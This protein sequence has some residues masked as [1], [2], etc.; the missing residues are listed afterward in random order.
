[1]DGIFHVCRAF[2]DSDVVHVEDRVDPVE[3]MAWVGMGV[4]SW[5]VAAAIAGIHQAMPPI[6]L[7]ICYILHSVYAK[8]L[9][10]LPGTRL[11]RR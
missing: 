4:V 1:M 2:D 7:F 5:G 3:G 6:I 8:P 10:I 9:T 11:L